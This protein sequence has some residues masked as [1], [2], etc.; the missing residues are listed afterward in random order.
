MYTAEEDTEEAAPE[1][2]AELLAH[3][4]PATQVY[5]DGQEYPIS[6]SSPDSMTPLAHSAEE[7]GTEAADDVIPAP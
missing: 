2:E 4:Q 7:G 6:H 3:L 1:E 5:P